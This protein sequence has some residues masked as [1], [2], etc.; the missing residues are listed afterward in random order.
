MTVKPTERRCLTRLT[1]PFAL[2]VFDLPGPCRVEIPGAVPN[3]PSTAHT[4]RY[5]GAP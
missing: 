4:V 3:V 2:P 1:E 5:L